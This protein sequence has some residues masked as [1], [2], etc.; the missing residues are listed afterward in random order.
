MKTERRWLSPLDLEEHP[1]YMIPRQ[2]QSKLR[3]RKKI[4]YS[5]IGNKYIRYD[6]Q[7]LNKWLEDNAVVTL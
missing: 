5:K 7:E 3:M 2:T 4:P 6:I 1:D